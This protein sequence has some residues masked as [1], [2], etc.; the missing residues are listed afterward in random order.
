[1]F[2]SHIDVSPSP[3]FPLPLKSISISWG[4]DFFKIRLETPT[5]TKSKGN[6]IENWF[7]TPNFYSPYEMLVRFC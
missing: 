7:K 2:L 1:M 6:L 3:S 5:G 4:E